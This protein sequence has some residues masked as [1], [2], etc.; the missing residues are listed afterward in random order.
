MIHAPYTGQVVMQSAYSTTG[1][2]PDKLVG[3]GRM[4]GA[5]T[6]SSGKGQSQQQKQESLTGAAGAIVGSII[7]FVFLIVL[8]LVILIV[9]VVAFMGLA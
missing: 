6:S 1:T 8:V 5:S 4:R 3:Y 9:V 7:G 2:G